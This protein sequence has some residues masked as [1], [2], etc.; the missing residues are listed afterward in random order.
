MGEAIS[1]TSH[2]YPGLLEDRPNLLFMLKCRQFI[3]MVNGCD[4]EV[5]QRQHTSV[6]QS[7]KPYRSKP[8]VNGVECNSD[9]KME[10]EEKNGYLNGIENGYVQP[11]ENSSDVEENSFHSSDPQY[12]GLKKMCGGNRPAVER[13]LD[14]GRE[15]YNYSQQL[16]HDHGSNEENKKMLQDAFSLLAYS[17]PWS[18]PVGWQLDPV[19]R[20]TVCAKLNSA[21][22]ESSNMAR[23]PPLEM[24]VSHGK[25]LLKLMCGSGLGASAF[26]DIEDIV[27]K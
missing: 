5:P 17:N 14:F 1:L 20:E 2:L 27:F 26:A 25:E 15:L 7:T 21:I 10:T 4:T 18:S 8:E 3:E 19:Q 23:R 12:S 16:F 11:E 6:I 22:L 9:G 13:M 24:I